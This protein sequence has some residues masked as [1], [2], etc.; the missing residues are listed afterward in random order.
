MTLEQE[1]RGKPARPRNLMQQKEPVSASAFDKP[2][3]PVL[4]RPA[5]TPGGQSSR[6]NDFGLSSTDSGPAGA[7]G[8]NDA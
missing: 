8:E 7:A 2:R 1:F 5:A 4:R 6:W 3:A